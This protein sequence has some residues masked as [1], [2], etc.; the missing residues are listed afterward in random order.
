MVREISHPYLMD[1]YEILQDKNNFYMA[2]EM[3]KEG[4][5]TDFI[6]KTNNTDENVA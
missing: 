2:C 6:L 4:E 1:V 3:C 5:L